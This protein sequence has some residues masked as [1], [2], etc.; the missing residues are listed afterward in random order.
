MKQK[1]VVEDGIQIERRI[2]LDIYKNK[3]KEY[4]VLDNN[5]HEPQT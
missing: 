5:K 3:L 4:Y 1:V 2:I